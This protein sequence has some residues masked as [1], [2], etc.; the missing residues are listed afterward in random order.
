MVTA[1]FTLHLLMLKRDRRRKKIQ[2]NEN[3]IQRKFKMYNN[4]QGRLSPI[5]RPYI[6][7]CRGWPRPATVGLPVDEVHS[8]LLDTAPQ[9]PQPNL[10]TPAYF[11]VGLITVLCRPVQLR[12]PNFG[13]HEAWLYFSAVENIFRVKGITDNE[14]KSDSLL[15]AIDVRS[16]QK[17]RHVLPNSSPKHSYQ[18]IKTAVL[19]RYAP[20]EDKNLDCLLHQ[21]KRASDITPSRLL[22]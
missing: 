17:L 21:T 7:R 14:I 5:H 8:P 12:C 6:V 1:D 4:M 16:F 11:C 22:A 20:S 19:Q 3:L 18:Q 2:S 9:S 15:A 10:L 13:E